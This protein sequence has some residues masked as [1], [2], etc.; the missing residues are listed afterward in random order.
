[1]H[2][3]LL[4]VRREEPVFQAQKTGIADGAVLADE[5]FLLRFFGG[6]IGKPGDDR[7]LIVNLGRDLKL[8]PAPE[9]LLAPVE[10]GKWEVQW[11]SESPQYGGNGT[12]DVDSGCG[13]KI[14][15]HAAVLLRPSEP[16]ELWQI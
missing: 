16:N 1:M 10:G 2:K 12:P 9:P 4:K 14:P 15:G 13:W 11:S 5:A 6:I 8:E 3:D 7:L